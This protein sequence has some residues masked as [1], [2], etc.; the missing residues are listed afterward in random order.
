MSS[1]LLRNRAMR[2]RQTSRNRE[3]VRSLK[4]RSSC[5]DCGTKE[6]LTFDHRPGTVKIDTVSNMLTKVSPSKLRREIA[7]CDIVCR[8]CH[9]VRENV[10]GRANHKVDLFFKREQK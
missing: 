3:I 5:V 10:R 2:E 6:D 8:T 4:E 7:K 1:R 9:N